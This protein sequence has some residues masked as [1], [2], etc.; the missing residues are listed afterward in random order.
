MT[1]EE[2]IAK[3][4]GQIDSALEQMIRCGA[5]RQEQAEEERARI[6]SLLQAVY[7]GSASEEQKAEASA[8]LSGKACFG[9]SQNA[10][11]ADGTARII[12]AAVL[13]FLLFSMFQGDGGDETYEGWSN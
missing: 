3:H 10:P 11:S 8:I 4:S 6:V 7:S 12:I 2:I 13:A 9:E 5:I 1:R